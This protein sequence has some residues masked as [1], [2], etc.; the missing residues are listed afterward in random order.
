MSDTEQQWADQVQLER[1]LEEA[2][3]D[4]DDGLFLTQRQVDLLRYACGLPKKRIPNTLLT[5]VFDDFAKT[6]GEKK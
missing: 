6:F 5:E 2:F 3:Q 1:E 4:I